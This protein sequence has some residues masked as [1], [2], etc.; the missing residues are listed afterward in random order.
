MLIGIISDSHDHLDNVRKAV[1]IFKKKKV[2]RV[3]HAGDMVSPPMVVLFDGLELGMVYGNNDGE[4]VGLP[5]K[6]AKIG[7]ELG[8]EVLEGECKQGKIALYHGTDST[9]LNALI[10]CGKYKIVITGHTHEVENRLDGVTRV[11][12]PG[13]AHGFGK[14]ATIMLYDTA[15]DQ[16]E[17]VEL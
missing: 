11:L 2:A 14:Q 10:R 3:Y 7:G 8:P 6:I 4:K 12:N 1:K 15:L 13:T 17:V 9:I 5:K 16:A